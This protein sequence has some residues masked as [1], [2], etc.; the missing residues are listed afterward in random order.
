[1]EVHGKTF[2]KVSSKL[3][4]LQ[5]LRSESG[6]L[7][8]SAY[9][10]FPPRDSNLRNYDWLPLVYSSASEYKDL[11][12]LRGSEHRVQPSLPVLDTADSSQGA[13]CAQDSEH[14]SSAYYQLSQEEQGSV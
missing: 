7:L 4:A 1:M 5:A 12:F 14:F 6:W 8:H 9:W 2:L 13:N 10:A 11:W 3:G